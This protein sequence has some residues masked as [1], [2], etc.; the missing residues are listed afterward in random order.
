MHK[1]N[2]KILLK[3]KNPTLYLYQ[4]KKLFCKEESTIKYQK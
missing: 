4:G 1:G 3:I 2:F